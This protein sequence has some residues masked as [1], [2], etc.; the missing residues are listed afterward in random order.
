[1]WARVV[2]GAEEE[3]SQ[4]QLTGNS[5]E[6]YS[7]LLEKGEISIKGN[8]TSMLEAI[9]RF[10]EEVEC[11]LDCWGWSMTQKSLFVEQT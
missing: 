4:L 8:D 9:V 7:T 10:I 2:K 3:D 1:M 11:L 5:A 6:V